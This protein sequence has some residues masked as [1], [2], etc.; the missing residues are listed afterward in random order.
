MPGMVH[1]VLKCTPLHDT[2]FK[3]YYYTECTYKLELCNNIL[4]IQYHN[5]SFFEPILI[6][7]IIDANP[8]YTQL[9]IRLSVK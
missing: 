2:I 5:L 6:I 9:P 4:D 8:C 7:Q 3:S 1:N